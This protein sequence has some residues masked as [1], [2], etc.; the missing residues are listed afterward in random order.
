[1]S[2]FRD[3]KNALTDPNSHI[4]WVRLVVA[5]AGLVGLSFALAA[6]LNILKDRLN[7][8]LYQYTWLAYLSVFAASL[9]ANLTII[10]PVP[11]A[12]AIMATAAQHFNPVLI[13]LSGAVGGTLGEISGYYAGRLGSKIAI[14]ESIISNK[15]LTHL[16]EKYGFWAITIIALQPVIPFDVGG[17]VAGA[18]KMPL[19]KFIPALFLGKFPKYLLLVY[20]SLGLIDF[21]PVWMTRY[22]T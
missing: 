2:V 7:F 14:P 5:F 21:L 16:I 6:I 1:M 4:H 15:R 17:M 20:A 10:A 3:T 12:I 8:D 22:F 11:F 19:V 9:L 13:A 18:S